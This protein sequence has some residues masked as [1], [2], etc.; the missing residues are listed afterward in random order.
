[1]MYHRR[2]SGGIFNRYRRKVL[3]GL[4]TRGSQVDFVEA[5]QTHIHDDETLD[6]WEDAFLHNKIEL[7]L[8]LLVYVFFSNDG[9]ISRRE[10]RQIKGFMKQ[11]MEHLSDRVRLDLAGY[12]ANGLSAERFRDIFTQKEYTLQL[13]EQAKNT[14]KPL[15]T[16]DGKTLLM[17]ERL[18]EKLT[19]ESSTDY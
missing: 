9:N 5:P 12:M 2:R 4:M 17:I 7:S 11:N 3:F 8:L 1:M 14:I 16:N 15:F 19:S 13:F 10:Y 6:Y 18:K